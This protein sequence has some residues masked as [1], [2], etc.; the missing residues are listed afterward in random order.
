MYIENRGTRL[1]EISPT[2]RLFSLGSFMKMTEV[3][4]IFCSSFFTWKMCCVK[5]YKKMFW[6]TF[7]A[8]FWAIFSNTQLV[9]LVENQRLRAYF[10]R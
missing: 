3:V 6:A 9:T 2:G 8:T 5:F 1:G 10:L 7:R 4:R